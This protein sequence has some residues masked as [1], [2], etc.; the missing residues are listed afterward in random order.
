MRSQVVP[1]LIKFKADQL[2]L[3]A[4][5]RVSESLLLAIFS[6]K[7]LPQP[8]GGSNKNFVDEGPLIPRVDSKYCSIYYNKCSIAYRS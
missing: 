4:A 7:R 3:F 1:T 2:V 6:R 8:G 5:V